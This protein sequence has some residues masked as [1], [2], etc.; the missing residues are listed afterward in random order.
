MVLEDY[1]NER[2][3]LRGRVEWIKM[4]E[5]EGEVRGGMEKS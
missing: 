3:R 1:T 5:T 4:L 2:K